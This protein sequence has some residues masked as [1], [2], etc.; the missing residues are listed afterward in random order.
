M[1]KITYSQA[2][3]HLITEM[4]EIQELNPLWDTMF[5]YRIVLK[6][7][8]VYNKWLRDPDDYG[9]WVRMNTL[10]EIVENMTEY[11]LEAGLFREE[12]GE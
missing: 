7:D 4:Q 12:E 10:A 3:N 6:F 11:F 5:M 8:S 2:I 1:R 9:L